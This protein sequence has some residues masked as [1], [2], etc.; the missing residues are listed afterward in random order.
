SAKPRYVR[1][2]LQLIQST[3]QDM[4]KSVIE[5][6]L[7]YCLKNRLYSASD[8]GDAVGYF[9]QNASLGTEPFS[10]AEIK[11][12]DWVRQDCSLPRVGR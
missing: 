12:I 11:T 9:R 6:A 5:R 3:L 2:Q 4:D 7:H 8:F 10:S 1:D